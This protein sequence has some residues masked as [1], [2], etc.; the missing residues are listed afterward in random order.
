MEYGR[1]TG[2]RSSALYRDAPDGSREPISWYAWLVRGRGRTVLVDTGFASAEVARKW[3]VTPFN[4]VPEMLERLGV[5][6]DDV[7]DVVITHLHWDHAGNTAPYREAR[8]WVPEADLAWAR[9]RVNPERPERSG[10]RLGDVQAI[11]ALETSGRLSAVAGEREVL[12]GITLHAGARHT[13]G[14]LWAEVRTGRSDIPV[15]VLA[16]DVAYLDKNV[17]T[18]TPPGGTLD[19][20]ADLAQIR[21]MLA[22]AKDGRW[23]VPGHDPLVMERFPKAAE[24]VVEITGKR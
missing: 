24:G 19:P 4:P 22:V 16:S 2:F 7:T 15:V 5:A 21:R 17:E 8:F 3:K 12:P 11:D 10:V 14:I 9:A 13:G 23:V 20:E 1:S 6:P 18:L